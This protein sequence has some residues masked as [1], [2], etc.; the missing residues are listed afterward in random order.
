MK[1]FTI[2][3][4]AALLIWAAPVIY[5]LVIYSSL[6]ATIAIHFG[7]DGKPN[8]YSE[9]TTIFVIQGL[10]SGVA[11]FLF[12]LM[13]YLPALDPKYK[14]KYGE[15]TYQKLAFGLLLFI[16]VVSFLIIDSAAVG[17]MRSDNFVFVLVSLLFVFLGNL[18]YNVKPNY[19]VGIRT[20]W[21]LE[22]E[23]TWKATHRLAAKLWVIG[24]LILTGAMLL[25]HGATAF[26][27]FMTFILTLAFIPMIYSY[28]YYRKHVSHN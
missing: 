14:A 24:G 5:L 26:T 3:D 13:R 8:G 2:I 12:L 27:V 1:K 11:A 22:N 10:L 20:P 16:S 9:R 25:M 21:T 6:P 18:M 15:Q 4:L 7:V 17:K 28:T 19:F 23:D